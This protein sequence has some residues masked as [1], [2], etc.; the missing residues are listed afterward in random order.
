MRLWGV[1]LEDER[2]MT[3]KFRHCDVAVESLQRITGE[4]FGFD[5]NHLDLA[6]RNAAVGQA[7]SWLARR[8]ADDR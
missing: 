6:S 5:V 7:R 1:L 3:G 2:V 4:S 8:L